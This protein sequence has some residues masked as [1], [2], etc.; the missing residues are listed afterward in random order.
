MFGGSS[1]AKGEP[2]QVAPQAADD[3]FSL[4]ELRRIYK[5]LVENKLV[6]EENQ[7]LVIEILRVIAEMVVYGDNKSELLFDFFC[8]KSMLSLF[9]EI[10]NSDPVCPVPVHVQILQ[11]LSILISCVKNDTSLYYLLSN[12]HINDILM[13]RHDFESDESLSAQFASFMKTLSLR[14]NDQTVQF[15][16][17]EDTGAFPLLIKAVELLGS[18][19]PMI[20][21][22][23]QSTIL[24]IFRVNEHRAL[25]Y[26]L[27]EDNL[28]VLLEC[29]A[30]IMRDQF[31]S[32]CQFSQAYLHS[33]TS[34]ATVSADGHQTSIKIEQNMD[35]CIISIEDWIYY[36]QDVYDL[37]IEALQRALSSHLLNT[38]VYPVLLETVVDLKSTDGDSI[39]KNARHIIQS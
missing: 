20:R 33:T 15:F 19:D 9:L 27:R 38:F 3:R 30:G 17:R 37:N 32:L 2:Q 24:N 26:A 5:Q 7:D 13:F 18:K 1:A 11:T 14:L 36:L 28:F 22:S 12:N 25:D 39:G 23:A 10:M 29:I 4:V 21:I 16:F 8:E 34:A 31:N 35:D 6:N